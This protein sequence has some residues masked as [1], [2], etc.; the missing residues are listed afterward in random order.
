MLKIEEMEPNQVI[1]KQ[2]DPNKGQLIY[3]IEGELF[4]FTNKGS[5]ITP[6]ALVKKEEFIGEVSYFLERSNRS[7]NVI[8]QTACSLLI[9]DRET[10]TENIPNWLARTLS[11]MAKKLDVLDQ[12][13]NSARIK[14]RSKRLPEIDLKE[15]RR[16]VTILEQTK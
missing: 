5:E 13:L 6:L 3:I 15:Q 10:L 14:R 11:S 4:V 8:T 12:A 2:G 16:I 7:A 9:I 1:F